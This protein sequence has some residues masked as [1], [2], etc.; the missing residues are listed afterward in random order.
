MAL[1]VSFQDDSTDPTFA[2]ADE[3]VLVDSRDEDADNPCVGRS[4]RRTAPVAPRTADEIEAFAAVMG[5]TVETDNQ[6]NLV[7]YPNVSAEVTSDEDT[8]ED[9]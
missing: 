6:G 2:S 8:D 3:S 7:L 1:F 9:A 5:W 4:V